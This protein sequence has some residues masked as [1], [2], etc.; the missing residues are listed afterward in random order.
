LA[1]KV[2]FAA[3]LGAVVV[4]APVVWG[5]QGIEL[6]DMDGRRVRVDSLLADGPVVLNFWATWCRPCRV[7][8][9]HLEAVMEKLEGDH[10]HFAAISLDTRRN[11]GK[12]EE[13]ITKN[14][15]KLPIYRDPEGTLAK[16]FKVTAIPT[17][18]L[19]DQ[20]AEIAF[21]TRGYRP[22][23]EVLLKK[24]IQALLRAGG[25]EEKEGEASE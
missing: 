6:R 22:G 4:G 24:E 19:L 3:L 14:Q 18:I 7:E 11:K 2:L 13:Y 8:M 17:T 12:V 10:V 1:R 21:R 16:K 5:M 23:D 25:E 15:V 9:P 20:D